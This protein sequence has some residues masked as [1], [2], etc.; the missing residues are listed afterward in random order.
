[1]LIS[2]RLA[3]IRLLDRLDYNIAGIPVSGKIP[4]AGN[5]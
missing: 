2:R 3:N 5:Y 4:R 1:M